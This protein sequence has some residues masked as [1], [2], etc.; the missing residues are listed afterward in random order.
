M[1]PICAQQTQELL[2]DKVM[3]NVKTNLYQILESTKIWGLE[4]IFSIKLSHAE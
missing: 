3:K 1:D 2:M 4:V